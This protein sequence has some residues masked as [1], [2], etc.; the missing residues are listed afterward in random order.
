VAS[1]LHGQFS[2]V[3]DGA[4]ATHFLVQL[5]DGHAALVAAGTRG[6]AARGQASLDRTSIQTFDK[7]ILLP[8]SF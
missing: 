6:V 4:G 3:L 8:G 2:S 1:G 5:G 7:G